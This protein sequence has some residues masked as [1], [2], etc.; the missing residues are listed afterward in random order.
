MLVYLAES[1]QLPEPVT[2]SSLVRFGC[3]DRIYNLLPNALYHSVSSGW[4]IRGGGCDRV[5]HEPIRRR[6][7]ASRQHELVSDMVKGF[8]QVLQYVGG[9]GCQFIG[10][11]INL[12]DV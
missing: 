11:P 9:N 8:S 10:H 2:L 6:A 5:I 12:R 3:V 4:V 7:A 1:I